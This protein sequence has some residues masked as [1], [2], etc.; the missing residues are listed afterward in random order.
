MEPHRHINEK[1]YK[2][3]F[4]FLFEVWLIYYLL[5]GQKFSSELA[6][7]VAVFGFSDIFAKLKSHQSWN[8]FY[9]FDTITF[10]DFSRGTYSFSQS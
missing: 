5:H 7:S 3:F 9:F 10:Q 4:F 6:Y 2:K 1:L 8:L